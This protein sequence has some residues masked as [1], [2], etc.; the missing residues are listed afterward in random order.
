M[1]IPIFTKN[2]FH[3]G[4]NLIFLHLLRALSK[5]HTV[6]EFVH[7]CH[8]CHRAQL[9]EA[10]QD[11]PNI[12]LDSIER[13]VIAANVRTAIDTWKN[14]DDAW[15]SSPLQYNWSSYTLWHHAAIARKMGLE[16]PFTCREHLL[17]DYPALMDGNMSGL[18]YDFLIVNSEP[19]S[20]QFG[21]MKQHGSGYMDSLIEA[22]FR[23]GHS[24]VLTGYCPKME[25]WAQIDEPRGEIFVLGGPGRFSLSQIGN[26]SMR[27]H[28]HIMVATGPMWPTLNTTNHHNHEGRKRIVLLDNGESVN[29]PF[30]DQ[31]S[32]VEEVFAIARE[33]KWI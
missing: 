27:C 24:L 15:T 18:E 33:E 32:S 25:E 20:G 21:P 6:R 1:N 19:S 3:L 17:F 23:K 9:Q 22:L 16:S 7:Y 2:Q 29:L 8:E 13:P 12:V 30:L 26:L 14:A 28:H 4:D 5:Q 11:V 10:V 31:V